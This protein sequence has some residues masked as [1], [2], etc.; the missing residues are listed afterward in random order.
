MRFLRSFLFS[1][2]AWTFQPDTLGFQGTTKYL[3][4]GTYADDETIPTIDTVNTLVLHNAYNVRNLVDNANVH[5]TPAHSTPVHTKSD[6]ANGA[7]VHRESANNVRNLVEAYNARVVARDTQVRSGLAHNLVDAEV[8]STPIHAVHKLVDGADVHNVPAGRFAR[9]F[10]EPPAPAPVTDFLATLGALDPVNTLLTF[11]GDVPS[12][13]TIRDLSFKNMHQMMLAS[14]PDDW[15]STVYGET[16][17]VLD[18]QLQTLAEQADIKEFLVNK[19]G[20]AYTARALS[21]ILEVSKEATQ[22]QWRKLDYYF[23]GKDT[24]NVL[25]KDPVYNKLNQGLATIACIQ[26]MPKL[27]PYLNTT[28]NGTA[29]CDAL[30]TKLIASFKLTNITS[31]ICSDP[32]AGYL[33]L[34]NT[35]MLLRIL[36]PPASTK[37]LEYYN[38]VMSK[39]E[40]TTSQY[41][42]EGQD[43]DQAAQDVSD[44]IHQFIVLVLS[45]DAGEMD[46]TVKAKY[47]ADIKEMV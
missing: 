8:L 14:I 32:S 22:D 13:S 36:S 12:S 1:G 46:P 11:V 44:F 39:L 3:L 30:F 18:P 47:S 26:A 10:V 17:P 34:S 5:S 33:E 16:R 24:G 41:M 4:V 9:V 29:W 37:P 21:G 43:T 25:S 19:F 6:L 38:K 40:Q 42:S 20:M 15:L 31:K 7:D 2:V 35:V 28:Y 45:T 23:M 27:Q